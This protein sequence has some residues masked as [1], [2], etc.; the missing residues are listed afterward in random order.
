MM[1]G[2][3]L[4]KEF[5]SRAGICPCPAPGELDYAEQDSSGEFGQRR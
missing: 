2:R 4:T 1:P 5:P 3:A